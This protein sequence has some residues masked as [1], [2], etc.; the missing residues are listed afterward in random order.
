MDKQAEIERIHALHDEA[1]RLMVLFVGPP[2]SEKGVW[3][4]HDFYA[5]GWKFRLYSR[6][7]G[8]FDVASYHDGRGI[9][10][11]SM[12]MGRTTKQ[13]SYR[14]LP[15]IVEEVIGVLERAT[16]LQRMATP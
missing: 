7:D 9:V 6:T 8:D 14:T 11:P 15:Y 12:T 2:Q 13:V 1:I 10:G 5:E 4:V 16:V 3:R